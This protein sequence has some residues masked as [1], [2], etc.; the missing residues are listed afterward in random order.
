MTTKQIRL[1]YLISQKSERQAYVE[2]TIEGITDEA[3][4]ELQDQDLVFV[5]I[6]EGFVGALRTISLT[7]KGQ[8]LIKDYC[9]AC[10]CMPCD[11]NWGHE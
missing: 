3:I 6:G 7:A 10:E 2:W 11:C 4:M 1:L 5:D 9:D 8:D